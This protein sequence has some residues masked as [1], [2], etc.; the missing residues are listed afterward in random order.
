MKNCL[1]TFLIAFMM[2]FLVLG[3]SAHA[4]STSDSPMDDLGFEAS[5]LSRVTG[6]T[7]I[8][9][10]DPNFDAAVRALIGK[11]EGN[12]IVSDVVGMTELD[13]SDLDI[14]DLT[15]IEYFTALTELHCAYN[16]LTTLDLSGNPA[17][18]VL[19]CEANYLT[20]LDFSQ[21]AQLTELYCGLSGLTTLNVSQC[22]L[23][24]ELDCV[25]GGLTALDVSHNPALEGLLLYNNEL[26]VLDVSH[27]P[28][29]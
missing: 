23:L 25:E 24:K 13:V 17:L 5:P 11:L 28:A 19:N 9:F 7:V 10:P 16:A 18:R 15:G 12:I 26:T 14:A 2:L 8:H 20:E 6:D 21:N 4:L 22:P 29:L 27:N 1:C 3:V